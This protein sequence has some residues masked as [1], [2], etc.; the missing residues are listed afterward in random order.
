MS[1]PG[2]ALLA[3]RALPAEPAAALARLLVLAYLLLRPDYR[4]EIRANFQVVCGHDAPRFWVRNGWRVGRN[5]AM[6]ARVGTRQTDAIIDRAMVYADNGIRRFLE[7]NVHTAMVCFHYGLWELL[8]KVFARRGLDVGVAAA[9]QRDRRLAAA[10]SRLRR[11]DSVEEAADPVALARRMRR[12]GLTGFMLDNTGRGRQEWSEAGGVCMRLPVTGF[13]LAA[14]A[15][16]KVALIA[17]FIEQGRLRVHI[18]S[19]PNEAAAL[20]RFV[21]IVRRRPEEWVFWGKAGALG[22]GGAGRPEESCGSAS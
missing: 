19:A 22:E 6:M 8:P 9:R 16:A 11:L 18:S 3:V 21:E 5:L 7:R 1:L 15:G 10:L 17:G 12:P 14:R 2:V 13:R 4:A 20:A